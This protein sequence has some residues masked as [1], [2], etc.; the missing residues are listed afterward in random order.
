MIIH[1]LRFFDLLSPTP[2]VSIFLKCY[3]RTGVVMHSFRFLLAASLRPVTLMT[4]T[5]MVLER[6]IVGSQLGLVQM[7][8]PSFSHG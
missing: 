4:E 2:D 8:Q 1:L 3:F 7:M 5:M 6:L